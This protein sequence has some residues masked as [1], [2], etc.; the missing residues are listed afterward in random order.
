MRHL[1]LAIKEGIFEHRRALLAI[2]GIAVIVVTIIQVTSYFAAYSSATCNSCHLMQPYVAMW[3]QSSHAGVACVTCHSEWRFVLSETYVK[4]ALGVYAPQLRAEVPDS[5][6]LSCHQHQD[7]DTDKPFLK[8]IHFS[9]KNHLGEMRRGKQLHCTSCH[10]QHSIMDATKQPHS[11]VQ[12]EVCFTCHFKGAEKGQAVTGCLTCHGPPKTV[13]THQGFKFDHSSYLKRDV[14]CSLCHVEVT[15]GDANVPKS[16]CVTCHVSRIE[17]YDNSERVHEIHLKRHQIDCLRCHD[18]LEHGKVAMAPALGERCEDCHKPTHT[19]QEQMYIGIGGEGVPD[20]PSTMFL[21]RVAC[22]SC[23]GEPG[24]DPRRGAEAL[25]KSCVTCHGKG[26]DRMVDDWINEVGALTADVGSAVARADAAARAAGRR[27]T[28]LEHS[29]ERAH[30]N[31]DFVRL[32]HGEHNI[33]YAVELLRV[34]RSDAAEVLKKT[35]AGSLPAQPLL[36]SASGYCRVCHSTSY[37]GTSIPFSGL[38]YD[39]NRHLAQGLGCE[40]CHSIEDHG[41]TTI[42]IE[43]CMACHHGGETKRTCESCHTAQASFYKGTLAGTDVKGDPDVMAKADVECASCHD[44][45]DKEPVV[46]V[47]QKACV[48]CH[49]KGFDEMVV[50]WI[51]EDQKHVQEL[52][53]LVAQ[54]RSGPLAASHAKEIDAADAIVQALVKAK[55]AHNTSLA[56]DAY[57]KAKKLLKGALPGS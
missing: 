33:R 12:R 41:K 26:F 4:Y 2:V 3:K 23:H 40:T 52:T 37:L 17:A 46:K 7:L 29:L 11:D 14:R 48:G 19:P 6:C 25:R 32:A 54:A 22:N 55:G 1:W 35:G 8:N 30:H 47:V 36:A 20:T 10:N 16:R 43:K 50:E 39:H 57:D 53:V 42:T 51:N 15:S 28:E 5:R 31:L 18:K 44:L 13:V 38:A 9:H 45:A 49:E 21:A 27:S 56:S 24:N 34:A